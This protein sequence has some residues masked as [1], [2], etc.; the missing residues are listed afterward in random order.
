MAN[1]IIKKNK[2]TLVLM[3]AFAIPSSFAT[4]ADDVVKNTKGTVNIES[5]IKK[6]E[7]K[8]RKRLHLIRC[9]HKL[10][11]LKSRHYLLL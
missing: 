11:H 5:T 6:V 8:K 2:I 4:V 10:F 1:F 9:R 7:D 3:M